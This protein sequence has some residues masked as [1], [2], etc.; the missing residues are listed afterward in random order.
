MVT[1]LLHS[2]LRLLLPVLLSP[3][4]VTAQEMAVKSMALVE[5]DMTANLEENLRKDLNGNYGGLVKVYLAVSGAQFLG[6]SVLGQQT[7]A[8]SEYWVFMAKDAFKL[9]V[10]APGY[11]PLEVNFRDHGIT[12]VESRRTYRLTIM[13][14]QA[15]NTISEPT[16]PKQAAA[17][18]KKVF[19]VN[20]VS[21]TMVYV[22]GGPFVWRYTKQRDDNQWKVETVKRDECSPTFMI[23]ETEVTQALWQAVTGSNPSAHHDN[24]NNPVE[25]FTLTECNEFISKLN[26]LTG[27]KFRLPTEIEWVYAASG[28]NKSKHFKYSGSNNVDDV[29]WYWKN[30]GDKLLL[31][32]WNYKKL[33]GTNR[34]HPVKTKLPNELGIYDMSGNVSELCVTSKKIIVEKG[35]CYFTP[36]NIYFDNTDIMSYSRSPSSGFRIVFDAD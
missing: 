20:G 22:E 16:P 13:L 15:S 33:D 5:N 3:L 23:G 30:S 4:T 2:W 31:G 12:G 10:T 24:P 36:I 21:F 28:G 26:T 34:S 7:A 27:M 1:R 8:V 19:T 18:S 14:P 6:P 32:K 11:L 35:G 25:S 9:Q 29:A 17:T